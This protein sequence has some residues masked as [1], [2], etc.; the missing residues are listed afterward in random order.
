MAKFSK[1]N[2]P[3]KHGRNP[4]RTVSDWMRLIS[5]SHIKGLNPIT[6]IKEKL[7]GNQIV[8]IQLFQK[9]WQDGDLGAMKEWM[10][11]L[12][13]KVVDKTE[14]SGTVTF[15]QM[16]SIEVDGKSLEVQTD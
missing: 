5:K 6:G 11:R 7:S 14:L 3:K 2:Q 15:K 16:G 8:A 9:I 12:E 13:G 10:D 1:T 4:G